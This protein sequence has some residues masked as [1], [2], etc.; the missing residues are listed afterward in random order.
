MNFV[1]IVSDSSA[2]AIRKP[3]LTMQRVLGARLSASVAHSNLNNLNIAPVSMNIV[4]CVL[5]K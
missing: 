1:R 3:Q 5:S 4:R 2:P